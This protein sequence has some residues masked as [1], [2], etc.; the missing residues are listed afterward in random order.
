MDDVPDENTMK[1][2]CKNFENIKSLRSYLMSTPQFRLHNPKH[3]YRGSVL[4]EPRLKVDFV[5]DELLLR[6]FNHIQNE[7]EELGASEPHWSVL[8]S[9]DLKASRLGEKELASFYESGKDALDEILMTLERNNLRNT[10]EVVTEYGCGLGRVTKWLSSLG[11]KVYGYDISSSHLSL[12]RKMLN[13]YGLTNT[14]L[15]HIK[16]VDQIIEVQQADFFYCDIVLQ[17]N[18]PPVMVY[19]LKVLLSRLNLG[20]VGIFQIPTYRSNYS[21]DIDSY[22][23]SI[24]SRIGIEM[25]VLPQSILFEIIRNAGC[26]VHEVVEDQKAGSP[27]IISNTFV[28]EKTRG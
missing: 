11:K 3:S 4:K 10:F 20:G 2:L 16:S 19:I 18:P 21:F 15:R 5:S 17:H 25:H 23:A 28:V 22:L 8:S 12:A 9:D 7:W 1:Y 6:L 24:K 26:I 27:D 14:Y 13:S